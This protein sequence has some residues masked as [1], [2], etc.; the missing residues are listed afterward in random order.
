MK[1]KFQI[2]LITLYFSVFTATAQIEIPKGKPQLV[3]FYNSNSKFKVP[4]GKSW[5]IV[6]VF[7]QETSGPVYV[8]MNSLNGKDLTRKNDFGIRLFESAKS[9]R[10][11]PVSLPIL[12]PQGSD[13]QL[14]IVSDHILGGYR[15]SDQTAWLNYIEVDN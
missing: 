8:Y 1:I 13:F 11:K 7:S 12:L 10:L 15:V 5:Y 14:V 2:L 3:E 6:N 4:E 9:E